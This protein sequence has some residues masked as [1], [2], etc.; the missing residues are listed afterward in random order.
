MREV[1]QEFKKPKIISQDIV[2]HIKNPVERIMFASTYD[3][4]GLTTVNTINC[5]YLNE[6]QYD[7]KSILLILNSEL[8]SWYAYRF[9]YNKAIRTM[10]FYEFFIG[11]I[12]ISNLLSTYQIL[13]NL[14]SQ[15]LL[16]LN[17]LKNSDEYINEL[18]F[19]S[20]LIV[21]YR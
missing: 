10:H 1:R 21:F 15:S 7:L 9:I 2:A 4:E 18:T 3:E 8:I 5:T 16:Y 17:N 6:Q 20:N 11:K 14:V 13:F 12:P 19:I